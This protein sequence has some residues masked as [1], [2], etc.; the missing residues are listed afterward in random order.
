MHKVQRKYPVC[1]RQTKTSEEV[2]DVTDIANRT[3]GNEAESS[4]DF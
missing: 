4:N 2:F 3:I 1:K